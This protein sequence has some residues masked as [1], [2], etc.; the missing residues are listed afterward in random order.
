MSVAD[1]VDEALLSE[2]AE[3]SL[4]ASVLQAQT[5]VKPLLEQADYTQVLQT[6]ASL[7]KPLTQFFDN[8]MVNSEDAALKNNRLALL[9]QVRALFLTVADIS[10]LQL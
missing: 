4:Y 6:L 3:Q 5:A 9:K 7:D 1:T 10:E 2:S 8:V